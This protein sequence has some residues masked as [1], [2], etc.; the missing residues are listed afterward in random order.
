MFRKPLPNAE[1]LRECF[2]YA[3]STGVLVWRHR[4]EH[5]FND[6]HRMR[7]ANSKCEGKVAGSLNPDGYLYVGVGG[8]LFVA[9]RIIWKLVTGA[10]PIDG[11]DH[12]DRTRSNNAWRNLREADQSGNRC[13]TGMRYNNTTGLKGAV[14]DPK[15]QKYRAAIGV[16]GKKI[17]LGLFSSAEDAH[18]AYDKAATQYHGE[19]KGLIF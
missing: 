18:A 19:F 17:Y 16:R 5:H 1:Y 2:D 6:L 3:P 9:H 7:V 10:D 15:L 14:W 12:I 11:L 13:N 4:P 8:E